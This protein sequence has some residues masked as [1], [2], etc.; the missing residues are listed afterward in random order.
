MKRAV[1]LGVPGAKRTVYL[2]KAARE[3][4]I[5]L[6][7]VSWEEWQQNGF[8]GFLFSE[9]LFLK[10]DP[11]E[12]N[13]CVLKKLNDLTED[14][15]RQLKRLARLPGAVFWNHPLAIAALLD[16]RR[17]KERLSAA[18]LPVTEQLEGKI[19]CAQELLQQMEMQGLHQVFVKP[20]YG[21]GAA[22][23]AAFRWQPRTGSMALY[24][25]AYQ[26]PASGELVNTKRLRR[27]D[28]PAQ[29]FS[30][31]DSILSMDCIVERWHAK[32]H[33]DGCSYDLRAVIQDQE[34][35]FLVARLSRGPITNL[36]LNNHPLE[37]SKLSL[38]TAVRGEIAE[39]CR[40]AVSCYPGLRSAGVDLLLE[41][42]SKKPRIIEMNGQG[43]LIYQDIYGENRI[44]RHQAERM[45][46]WLSK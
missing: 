14:Y 46:A 42:G 6:E 39:L 3:A 45:K 28:K 16:K 9:K 18:G 40:R 37:E 23:V 30:L 35:D 15:R 24:T 22:G 17:C 2:E 41:R 5:P 34:L 29:I 4:G 19:S 1:L 8:P 13:C 32:A 44:Y 7:V 12:W 36:H 38:P 10:C 43:D 26:D 27:F 11:P 33:K 25:C 21:S 31:L 20:V